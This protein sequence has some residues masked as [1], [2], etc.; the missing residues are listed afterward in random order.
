LVKEPGDGAAFA[1]L[2]LHLSMKLIQRRADSF[3]EAAELGR[4]PIG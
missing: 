2:L 1:A 3:G 4:L